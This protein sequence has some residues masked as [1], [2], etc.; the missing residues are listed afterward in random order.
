MSE[1]LSERLSRL[2]KEIPDF[3]KPGLRFRDITPILTDPAVFREAT[4]AFAAHFA[5]REVDLLCGI[6][7]R[8]YIFGAALAAH[9]GKGFLPVQWSER[10]PDHKSTAYRLEYWFNALE[11]HAESLRGRRI[12]M[13]DDLLATGTTLRACVDLVRKAGG[14]PV[15]AAV[16]VEIPELEGRRQVPDLEV[17]SLCTL[18]VAADA[19]AVPRSP[20]GRRK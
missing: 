1:P 6:E 14:N 20:R 10:L 11:M 5:G 9:M 3:P 4:E 2:V 16:V 18:K 17:H 12:L 15:A 7:S 13:V 19:P 8:G